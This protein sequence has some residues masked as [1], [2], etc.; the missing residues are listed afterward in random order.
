M[1]DNQYLVNINVVNNNAQADGKSFNQVKVICMDSIDL[2]PAVGLEVVFTAISVRGTAFFRENNAAV[3]PS[4]TDGIGVASAN[5][6]DTIAEDI[7]LKCHVKSDN[8]SQSSVS[9]TFRA[10]TGKFEIT[11]ASN[12]NATFS[13]G[14]PTIAWGGAEFVIDTQG[15]SGDV[16]WSINNIVSEI[17]I[18]EGAQQNAYVIIGEDP[19]KEVRITA[20][21]RVTGESDM[22]TFYLRYFIRSDRQK[23]KYSDAV[24]S[25]GSYMLPVA[26]YDQLYSQW[27]NLAMYFIWSTAIDETYWTK[28][29][30]GFNFNSI[31]GVPLIE[32]DK[33]PRASSR[34][35][36]DVRTGTKSSSS[37]SSKYKKYFMYSLP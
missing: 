9:L 35:V 26:V 7:V 15:G 29:L 10:A 33:T 32:G 36:F 18:R 21:D 11:N 30:G 34:I 23:H 27:R 28:D 12:I 6:G 1:A 8:T 14:E 24:A 5:I 17:T 3:Y 22:Y 19:R 20:R 13:P 25:F 31:D 37:T 16:E 4:V 2:R